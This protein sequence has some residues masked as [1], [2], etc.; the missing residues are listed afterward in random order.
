MI[1]NKAGDGIPA[2]PQL[3]TKPIRIKRTILSKDGQMIEI[4]EIVPIPYPA[5]IHEA[6]REKQCVP[7]VTK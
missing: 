4:E 6:T 1:T 2:L 7:P 5:E 3:P